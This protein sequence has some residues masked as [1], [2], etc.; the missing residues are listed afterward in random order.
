MYKVAIPSYKRADA[1]KKK[2]LETLKKGKVP[3]SNIY[4]FVANKDEQKIYEEAIPQNL[5]HKIVVGIKGI[6]NQ[7]IFIRNYFKEGEHVV[8]MDDD[9]ESV[10]KLVGEKFKPVTNLNTFFTKSFKDLKKHNLYLWG[11]Y[12]VRN[13]FFMKN[14]KE[15][16]STELK[17]IIGV[18]HGYIVRHD[19]SLNPSPKAEGKEDYE[20]A[21]RYFKK[22]GG[23]LR[24][25]NITM[26]TKFLAKGGL[27]EEKERFE[28]NRKAA[29]YLQ[30]TYPDLVTIFHRKNGM[31]EIR[32]RD[33]NKKKTSAS[34]K[35]KKPKSKKNKT[36]K[37]KK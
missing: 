6:A 25:N 30:K 27:G 15:P 1:L 8:S 34:T 31:T 28:I 32:L 22:D 16:I 37:S 4:I 7:R 26:K 20:Q 36:K 13:E 19:K 9:V 12:P 14:A 10:L 11:V 33:P 3:A 29:E 18:I 23:V 2:T 24:Y 17:F 21:I 5:Y 35:K